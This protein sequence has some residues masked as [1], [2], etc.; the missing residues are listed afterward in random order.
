MNT[1]MSIAL[2]R[3]QVYESS[4]DDEQRNNSHQITTDKINPNLEEGEIVSFEDSE[5]EPAPP[6]QPRA[7]YLNHPPPRGSANFKKQ[8][9]NY[10]FYRRQLEQDD[11]AEYSPSSSEDCYAQ[12]TMANKSRV[13][14]TGLDELLYNKEKEC[15]APIES[16]KTGWDILQYR[17]LGLQV[18]TLLVDELGRVGQAVEEVD[19]RRIRG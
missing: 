16:K 5:L 10:S 4:D 8:I 7:S 13:T 12:F 6:P 14:R 9:R 19:N 2:S 17:L 1:S 3:G 11:E 18:E 15:N